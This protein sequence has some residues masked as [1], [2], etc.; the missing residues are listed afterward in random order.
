[1]EQHRVGSRAISVLQMGLGR[2]YQFHILTDPV[3]WVTSSNL[4]QHLPDF[5]PHWSRGGNIGRLLPY[6]EARSTAS[7]MSVPIFHSTRDA[8][9][10]EDIPCDEFTTSPGSNAHGQGLRLRPYLEKRPG[11]RF[12]YRECRMSNQDQTRTY[13]F[14]E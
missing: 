6:G 13:T 14:Q 1:M 2:V 4:L 5:A 10:N 3:L 11:S 9:C 7:T 12:C 8:A